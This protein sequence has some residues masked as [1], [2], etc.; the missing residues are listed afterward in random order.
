MP[1]GECPRHYRRE[2]T[3]REVLL[4][5]TYDPVADAAYVYLADVI[6]GGSVIRSPTLDDPELRDGVF[7]DVNREGEVV[8]VEL[9]GA[10]LLSPHLRRLLVPRQC[11]R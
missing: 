10:A 9:L 2:V 5:V 1:F 8:G 6:P 7:L 4:R 11:D 3:E